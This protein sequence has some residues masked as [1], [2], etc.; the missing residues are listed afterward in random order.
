[1]AEQQQGRERTD[2]ATSPG[3]AA[4]ASPS[5]SGASGELRRFRWA[6]VVDQAASAGLLSG[7]KSERVGGRV[8]KTLL[9]AAMERTG[10]RSQTKLLEYALAKVAMEDDYGAKLLEM[11]G[12][13]PD[14]VEL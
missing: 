14:D 2:E 5:L 9:S 10:I 8:T 1:M 13:V 7:E 6:A 4:T 3:P 12:S 11:K